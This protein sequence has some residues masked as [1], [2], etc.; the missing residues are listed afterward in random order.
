MR[1]RDYFNR[2]SNSNRIYTKPE[3]RE[4]KLKDFFKKKK[5]FLAQY[6]DIGLP[7][8]DDLKNSP[9]AHG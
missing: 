3:I 7:K 6:E 1:F 5:E 9:N 4:M 2:E 8:L